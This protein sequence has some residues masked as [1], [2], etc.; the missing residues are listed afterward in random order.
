[1]ACLKVLPVFLPGKMRLLHLLAGVLHFAE[2]AE[3]KFAYKLLPRIFSTPAVS[4]MLAL[5]VASCLPGLC[6]LLMA[7]PFEMVAPG[8]CV[9]GLRAFLVAAALEMVAQVK[10][11]GFLPG[12]QR[13]KVQPV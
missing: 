7:P 3:G 1:M 10:S 11:K 12:P 9:Q 4:E 8:F 2:L 13:R 6:A 5:L